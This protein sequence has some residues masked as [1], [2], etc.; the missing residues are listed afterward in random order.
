MHARGEHVRFDDGFFH[1]LGPRRENEAGFALLSE[2]PTAKTSLREAGLSIDPSG[3]ALTPLLPELKTLRI[4][5][6]RMVLAVSVNLGSVL[7]VPSDQDWLM[8]L[9]ARVASPSGATPIRFTCPV[10]LGSEPTMIP[11]TW[12]P[13][14]SVL[15]VFTRSR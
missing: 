15:P 13:W 9:G 4:P 5:A 1:L 11:A 12:V 10:R 7:F 14:V 6:S 2:A 8:I 3:A